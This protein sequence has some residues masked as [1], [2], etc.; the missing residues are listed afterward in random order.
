MG[1]GLA[2]LGV[3]GVMGGAVDKIAPT[4]VV[5]SAAGDPVYAAFSVT[6][7]FSEDVTGF[8]IGDITVGN[9]AASNFVAV[10]GSVYTADITPTA[11]G[12]VT[13]DVGAGVCTDGAGNANTA[14]AQLGR[15]AIMGIVADW[16]AGDGTSKPA[17]I[18][19]DGDGQP[20]SQW[21][22]AAGA[23]FDLANTLTARP[24]YDQSV[25]ALGNRG[26]VVFDETSSQVL[27]A[28]VAAS[29]IA[30]L[31]TYNIFIVFA[32]S[33]T[34]VGAMYAEGSHTTTEPVI[35]AFVDAGDIGGLIRDTA[36]GESAVNTTG[37]E[38]NDGAA[39]IMTI[40]RINAMSFEYRIDGGSEIVQFQ[41]PGATAITRIA[42]GALVRATTLN[43]FTGTIGRVVLTSQD[44]YEAVE[45]ILA[46]HYGVTLAT[47]TDKFMGYAYG[48]LDNVNSVRFRDAAIVTRGAY[49]AQAWWNA[50][51]KLALAWRPAGG[52]WSQIACDG[53]GGQP[54]IAMTADN[55]NVVNVGIDPNGYL[56]VA[57][58]MH[59]AALLYRR[60]NAP[61]ATWTGTLTDAL[62]MVGTNETAVTY[63]TFCNDPAGNLYFLFR[64]GTSGH[65]DLYFYQYAH[66]TTT[67]TAATGTAAGGKLIDGKNSAGDESPYWDTPVFDT[68]FGSGGYMH[69]SWCWRATTDGT[70]NHDYC[71]MRWDG[72]NWTT[73]A[74]AA[75]TI[76]AT[77]A[78][79]AVFDAS[80]IDT[81]LSN[82][83]GLDADSDGHPHVAFFKNGID[84]YGHLYHV[85]HNG[86]AW[87]EAALTTTE[88]PAFATG[89]EFLDM[90]RPLLFIDRATDTVY[91]VY[92]DDA[93]VNG[94]LLQTSGAGDYTSWTKTVLLNE[95]V[96]YY[97][98][99]YD[100]E[101]W[102]TGR[103]LVMQ[104]ARWFDTAATNFKL[105]LF[106]PSL[107]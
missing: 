42:I 65:G 103:A 58:N 61:L 102:R 66:A 69:L 89:S 22:S 1:K 19:S 106:E 32:T 56:H 82:T 60:S 35:Q 2:I 11:T 70:D 97:E 10:S 85:W 24:T 12:A 6:F 84:G 30:N 59:N 53:T 40:R 74:G 72:T 16:Y 39:H 21:S 67:W 92:R 46:T 81:G 77:T 54:D 73:I 34:A 64:D 83:N 44:N 37:K 5:S 28:N 50:A 75:Q 27:T 13:V 76:P 51:G 38:Y 95:D 63:P 86:T 96:G 62:A 43:Y 105:T 23:G 99:N 29:S 33:G 20:V 36:G 9:G 41:S 14:A 17:S 104:V 94:L 8:V 31:N 87:V 7:T 55:H 100:R 47:E 3:P 98:P 25:A 49:Q 107:P 52:A 101:A 71:Y 4:C 26:G 88:T 45:S 78:N 68:N 90:G 79:D 91:I 18:T 48:A 93:D 57:Y 15:I 80:L